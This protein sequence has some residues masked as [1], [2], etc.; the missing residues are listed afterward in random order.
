MWHCDVELLRRYTAGRADPV[1]S[2]SVEAHLVRC[3]GCRA[4]LARLADRSA[5]EPVWAG[6]RTAIARLV[7][8]LPLRLLRRLGLP[9]PDAVLLA[10]ARSLRGPWLLA[11]VTVLVF[12][13]AAA[14]T[15]GRTGLAAYLLV[16]PL[17]PVLGVVAAFSTDPAL[18]ELTTATP[19]SKVR[20][21]LLRTAAVTVTTVPLV[22]AVGGA[23][24]GVGW[25]AFAWLGPALGLTVA[26][27]VAL[28]WLSPT[29]TGSGLATCWALAVGAGYS[30]RDLDVLVGPDAQVGY[31][32]LT[33]LAA[34]VL[35]ARLRSARTPGGYA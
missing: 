24:P 30:R 31:L 9:E 29:V 27:L 22:A 21:A 35:A 17:V 15:G 8:P 18:A 20:L 23:L 34:A 19:Y 26:A 33:V 14:W 11:T 2:A 6:V 10:A 1:L 5:F 28:T 13:V 25:L 7:P 3:A 12:A 4:E 16:A 32:V